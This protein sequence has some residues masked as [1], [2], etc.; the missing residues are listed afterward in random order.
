MIDFYISEERFKDPQLAT[1]CA[2]AIS[3]GMSIVMR[4]HGDKR[5]TMLF[6]LRKGTKHWEGTWAVFAIPHWTDAPPQ[7]GDYGVC[8]YPFKSQE[9]AADFT[10]ALGE[11]TRKI[12]PGLMGMNVDIEDDG[13][14][15]MTTFV[16]DILK[17]K[18]P[19]E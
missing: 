12:T 3:M 17:Q 4:M 2:L 8:F 19:G 10:V 6:H 16:Q 15:E 5:A 18:G 9:A 11:A 1:K 14:K 7:E 13:L